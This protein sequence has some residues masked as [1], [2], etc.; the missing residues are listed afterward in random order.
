MILSGEHRFK[1]QHRPSFLKN[2]ENLCVCARVGV[3]VRCALDVTL[4][5]MLFKTIAVIILYL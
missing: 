1:N 3:R 2:R 5:I 4:F